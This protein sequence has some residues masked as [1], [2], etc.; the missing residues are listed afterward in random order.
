MSVSLTPAVHPTVL[1]ASSCP[2]TT[3]VFAS[4][5]SQAGNVRAGLVCVSL[6]LVRAV[7]CV[8]CPAALQR[9]TLAHV[10]L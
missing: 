4:L 9:D 3:N 1:T 7:E 6:S 8:R 2:M 10:S 5:D